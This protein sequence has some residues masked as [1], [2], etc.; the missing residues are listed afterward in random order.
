MSASNQLAHKVDKA[1]LD[2]IEAALLSHYVGGEFD[3][4]VLAGPRKNGHSSKEAAA[5]SFIQ[6]AVPAVTGYC[7]GDLEAGTVVRV[8]LAAVDIA[9]RSVKFVQSAQ[10]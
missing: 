7:D 3:A 10:I 6:I 5:R 9:K 1:A 2:T 4:V 8:T